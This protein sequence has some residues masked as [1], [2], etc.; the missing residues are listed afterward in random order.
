[1]SENLK[2]PVA[3]DRHNVLS[4]DLQEWSDWHLWRVC[5]VGWQHYPVVVAAAAVVGTATE[6][7]MDWEQGK[8]DDV[9]ELML[10]T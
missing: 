9:M 6:Y 10:E 2:Q 7:G 8:G 4:V 1:M 5:M 3:E